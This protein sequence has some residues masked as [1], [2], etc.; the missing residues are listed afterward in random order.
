MLGL[1][2]VPFS[3]ETLTIIAAVLAHARRGR[4]AGVADDGQARRRHHRDRAPT[5]TA[6]RAARASPTSS[7]ASS[8]AWPGC[9]MIGQT[10]INVRVSGA[11]TRLSTFCAGALP[12]RPRRRRSAA[13]SRVIP[14]AALVAVMILVVGL[15]VRLAQRS[16][17][18]RC[19]GCRAARRSIMARHR[20]R[21]RRHPQPRD[22]RRRRRA[23]RDGRLRPQGRA[24][25][26]R[27]PRR[28]TRTAR[29]CIYSV[30]G[31]LFFASDQE[32]IDAF[33]Y[34][35]DPPKRHHRPLP[36]PRLGRL[37]RRRARRHRDAL[38]PPRRRTRD[39]RPQRAA[40]ISCTARSP[41]SW[42]GRTDRRRVAD[43]GA[44][45]FPGVAGNQNTE[46]R[47]GP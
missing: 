10:M 23:H 28:S 41:G 14:M 29:P 16:R 46:L 24:P 42:R 37:R 9:A 33:D 39:H 36:R 19:A 32:L 30:T 20:R 34:A 45:G 26:R 7:P 5:R 12:A 47:R 15:D 2:S 13:S 38:P 21:H 27:R 3:L 8:A 25:R 1:P 40:A 4:P 31:E 17:P 11:R 6:R 44:L 35:D 18:R 22:R 43:S